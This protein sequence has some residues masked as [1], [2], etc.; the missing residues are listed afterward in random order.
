M[1]ENTYFHNKVIIIIDVI[2]ESD[3]FLMKNHYLLMKFSLCL[4]LPQENSID[5]S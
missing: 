1:L 3:Y 4:C 2:H 5:S